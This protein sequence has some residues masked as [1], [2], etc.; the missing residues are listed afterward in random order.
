MKTT[1]KA[2]ITRDLQRAQSALT[3]ARSMASH[4]GDFMLARK[5][6]AQC[7]ALGETITAIQ[8]G[9]LKIS[10]AEMISP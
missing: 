4:S 2:M 6:R 9:P 8:G 7:E 10:V 3:A 5:L 1:D